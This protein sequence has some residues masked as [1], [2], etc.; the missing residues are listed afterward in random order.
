MILHKSEHPNDEGH[1]YDLLMS[2]RERQQIDGLN[3]LE[4][5]ELD[6]QLKQFYTHIL[7]ET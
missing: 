2:A 4:Y 7:V 6:Y 3:S 1:R 5:T